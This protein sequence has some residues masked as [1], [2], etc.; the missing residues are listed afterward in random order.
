MD[1]FIRPENLTMSENVLG[2]Q[3]SYGGTGGFSLYGIEQH[4]RKPK[5]KPRFRSDETYYTERPILDFV[6]LYNYFQQ[7]LSEVENYFQQ[8]LTEYEEPF[9]YNLR[10]YPKGDKSF[11]DF[12]PGKSQVQMPTFSFRKQEKTLPTLKEEILELKEE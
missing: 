7:R 12:I 10:L 8:R 1:N 11:G 3:Y 4:E 2:L 6:S 9:D 5:E